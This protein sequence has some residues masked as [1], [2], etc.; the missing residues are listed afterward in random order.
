MVLAL[1]ALFVTTGSIRLTH[2]SSLTH[3][4]VT[5]EV[6]FGRLAPGSSVGVNATN[7]SASVAASSVA[8]TTDL[9][10]LNNTNATAP[11]FAK[12]V[13]TGSSGLANV[14]SL[15]IGIHNGTS[16]VG[17]VTGSFGSITQSG[18]SYVRLEPASVNR[19][20]VTDA[21]TLL[22]YSGSTFQLDVYAADATNESAYVKTRALV[23][24]T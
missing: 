12:L 8:T 19:I 4:P 21:V 5:V 16:G 14:V 23:S 20:Y 7:A 6:P 15:S 11:A 9:L 3:A 22:G 1:A 10:Y 17:Q 13:L 24:L 18:G 2:T